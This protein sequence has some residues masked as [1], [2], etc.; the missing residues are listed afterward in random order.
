VIL[1]QFYRYCQIHFTRENALFFVTFVYHIPHISL[2]SLS[3]LQ[4]CRRSIFHEKGNS[5]LAVVNDQVILRAKSRTVFCA[6]FVI[7]ESIYMIINYSTHIVRCISPAETHNL[8]DIRYFANHF[9][10]NSSKTVSLFSLL[11]IACSM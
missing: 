6:H 1:G 10:V 8:C 5:T 9:F 3:I 4:R 7:S 11:H 2:N